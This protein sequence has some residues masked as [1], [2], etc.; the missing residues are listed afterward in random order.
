M[1]DKEKIN[2]TNYM[3]EPR[4]LIL[5]KMLKF[6]LEY[7]SEHIGNYKVIDKSLNPNTIDFILE[8]TINNRK[9]FNK[10]IKQILLK[11][12]NN[13]FFT[14]LFILYEKDKENMN[15]INHIND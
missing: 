3:K 7:K 10:N 12:E 5:E 1:K 11:T 6:Y 2:I 14:T 13:N 15:S 4:K 8:T 9:I